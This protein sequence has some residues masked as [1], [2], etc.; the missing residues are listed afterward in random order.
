MN[1]S[2]NKVGVVFPRSSFFVLVVQTFIS[3]MFLFSI[4]LSCKNNPQQTKN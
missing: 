3:S 4:K 2:R 1:H